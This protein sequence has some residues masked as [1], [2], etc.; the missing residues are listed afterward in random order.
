MNQHDTPGLAVESLTRRISPAIQIL[1]KI[2]QKIDTRKKQEHERKEAEA[3]KDFQG[4]TSVLDQNEF[5]Y[6]AFDGDGI[7]NKVAQAE[8]IDDE[9][10]L[11]E[12]GQAINRGQAAAVEFCRKYNGKMIEEGGD[13]GIMKVPHIALERVEQFRQKYAQETNASLTVGIGKTIAESTK[14][15][16]LGK[17]RGK[18]TAVKFDDSTEKELK[19]RQD[20]GE[21]DER[22]KMIA[23]G[24]GAPASAP[25][26]ETQA[27]TEHKQKQDEEPEPE[28]EEKPAPKSPSGKGFPIVDQRGNIEEMPEPEEESPV[29]PVGNRP[30]VL[31]ERD[32]PDQPD[33]GYD[34]FGNGSGKSLKKTEE[35]LFKGKKDL[36]DM[37]GSGIT[38]DQKS[39]VEWAHSKMPNEN[40][41][42]WATR[43]H[44][45]DS[46][47]FTPEMKQKVEHFAGSQHLPEVEKLRFEKHHDLDTG[48][49]MMEDAEGEYNKRIGA[50][51]NLV[52]PDHQT[53]K[54]MDV[55]NNMS[56]FSLG[57]GSCSAEG[58]AMGHCGNVPSK[59][60]GDRV[61]SLRTVHKDSKGN[62]LHEPHATFI[63][64]GGYLGEMKGRGNTKPAKKYHKAVADLLLHPKIKGIVG[65][66]YLHHQNFSVNDLDAEH[67]ER[68]I[69]S[70]PNMNVYEGGTVPSD[71]PD[72]FKHEV[73]PIIDWKNEIQKKSSQQE[74]QPSLFDKPTEPT[75][76]RAAAIKEI[77]EGKA[78][79]MAAN[80]I[81]NLTDDELH[82]IVAGSKTRLDSRVQAA[83][84]GHDSH[85]LHSAL[86][87]ADPDSISRLNNPN[88][89]AII[90]TKNPTA[91]EN[92]AGNE[93]LSDKDVSKLVEH[94]DF[95][96]FSAKTHR[97]LLYQPAEKLHPKYLE[98]F[99]NSP[100][101]EVRAEAARLDGLDPK[102]HEKL[103]NDQ[104]EGVR[105]VLTRHQKLSPELQKKMFD[106]GHL[107]E[108]ADNPHL[109]PE[110]WN[111]LATQA[112]RGESQEQNEDLQTALLGNDSLPPEALKTLATGRDP[113][114]L[115][116]IYR[117]PN[118][119]KDLF[120]EMMARHSK[121]P[122]AFDSYSSA[123]LNN[124]H[125]S[126]DQFKS[127]QAKFGNR[128]SY[129]DTFKYHPMYEAKDSEITPKSDFQLLQNHL[130]KLKE[131]NPEKYK[132]V[133]QNLIDQA[134]K[135]GGMDDVHGLLT[136]GAL[137]DEHHANLL[138]AASGEIE[139]NDNH[140]SSDAREFNDA[141]KD[142]LMDDELPVGHHENILRT[143]ERKDESPSDIGKH[144]FDKEVENGGY[145]DEINNRAR[146]I[147]E[148][149]YPFKDYLDDIEGGQN[150]A[151][152]RHIDNATSDLSGFHEMAHDHAVSKLK[153]QGKLDENGDYSDE[154]YEPAH[155]E[156]RDE[157]HQKLRDALENWQSTQNLP[158]HLRD[159]VEKYRDDLHEGYTESSDTHPS[160]ALDEFRD[161]MTEDPTMW[162]KHLQQTDWVKN[163]I[164][165]PDDESEA[166]D[167]GKDDGK[168]EFGIAKSISEKITRLRALLRG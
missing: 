26:A 30:V 162:P 36:M 111:K 52:K 160:A 29:E 138:D 60:P 3:N 104:N 99:V 96:S 1:Q 35:P 155:E 7:G 82:S 63:A 25:M 64:N 121:A 92:L 98:K 13:S 47:K 141:L 6:L 77:A 16:Q 4:A 113:G 41:S 100:H 73:R 107:H 132:A 109:H 68:V 87:N 124:K 31:H 9:N 50:N 14:A 58:K 156:A 148:E 84:I 149:N 48:V 106:K 88:I 59:A 21:N 75:D 140:G 54:I 45:A 74:I 163:N 80:S 17:L 166:V 49:K 103:A 79:S 51:L 128:R 118:L 167:E 67:R 65:G 46:S 126:L 112:A 91:I 44:R 97:N 38:P 5:Y 20:Q 19:I 119:P 134:M 71:L 117:H 83:M 18:N 159:P 114:N 23:A 137:D 55:G 116:K 10:A 161:K 66:G 164:I 61:L 123:I 154:D 24:M 147:S 144:V 69:K 139:E 40:W 76:W 94:P 42:L 95:D 62:E 143:L 158:E 120:D 153:E 12:Q 130:N 168:D 85:R 78:P 34:E 27:D 33:D 101:E 146:E 105:K 127:L 43:A 2:W 136:S 110:M 39:H 129:A 131:K 93:S 108:L 72:K 37:Y 32:E 142:H 89:D 102:F 90:G 150:H 165:K 70:K 122:E 81:S 8:E 135:S 56:W 15:R 57:R 115:T 157:V 125:L 11:R 133:Q 86:A 151:L 22:K 145:S 28:P 152:D 53:K